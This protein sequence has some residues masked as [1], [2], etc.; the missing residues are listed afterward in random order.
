MMPKKSM[1]L[2]LGYFLISLMWWECVFAQDFQTRSVSDRVLIVSSP[3]GGESQLVVKSA[4]GLVV[5]NTFW[6]EITARRFRDEIAKALKRD[7]FAYTV[8]MTD[9]LDMFGGNAAYSDTTIIGQRTFL[10]K[11]KGKEADVS[12]EIK[13]LI[14]MWRWKEGVSRERLE[15]QT[16]GSEEAIGE[17][18]WMNTCKQ[19]AD[20]LTQGFSLHGCH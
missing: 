10:E 6:S 3:G 11:Y 16:P 4:N 12:A 17:R 19:R 20:E 5:F 14:D 9:R 8:N 1:I 13:G 2:A 7:D 15:K 18:R